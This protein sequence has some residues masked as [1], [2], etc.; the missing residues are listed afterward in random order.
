M[1]RSYKTHFHLEAK[2]KLLI[3]TA[4]NNWTMKQVKTKF[5]PN[6]QKVKLI[7]TEVTE[8]LDRPLGTVL[9]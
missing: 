2:E 5:H 1:M 4:T 3:I 9:G 8:E 6:E 7:S